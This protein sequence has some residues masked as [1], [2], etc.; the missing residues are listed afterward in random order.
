MA[1]N[2]PFFKFV[3][4]EWLT[5]DIVYESLDVQG[6]FINICALYWQRDGKLSIDDINMRYKQSELLAKLTDR[7][8]S[9]NEGFVSI[10]FL[11]EQ[12]IDANHIS[13]VNSNNGKLGGRPKQPKPLDKK[14]TANRPLTEPKAK[15]SKEEEEQEVNKNEIIIKEEVFLTPIEIA[16]NKFFAFRK[17]MKKPILESSKD[18]LRDKLVK[19]SNN[20]N[21]TAIEIINQSIANGWQGLFELKTNNNG[22]TNTKQ[23]SKYHN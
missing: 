21:D 5:G 22:T 4:T 10:N 8:F 3:A 11:D 23:I 15:K 16:L 1:K 14:P 6:L 20:D 18:A 9:V 19:L 12:L 2:F 7:F 13:K 17:E